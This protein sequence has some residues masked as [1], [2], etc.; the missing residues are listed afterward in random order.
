[1][2][3]NCIETIR[4][5]NYKGNMVDLS[6]FSTSDICFESIYMSL[7]RLPRFGGN[8]RVPYTVLKHTILGC[9]LCDSL[10]LPQTV[11]KAYFIHDMSEGVIGVDIPTP[12]KKACFSIQAIESRIQEVLFKS[13]NAEYC[14]EVKKLDYTMLWYECENLMPNSPAVLGWE[15]PPYSMPSKIVADIN[16]AT[17]QEFREEWNLL[18]LCLSQ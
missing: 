2:R 6:A 16:D 15:P 4:I 7:S 5:Q 14:D 18:L 11:R 9:R 13:F 17:K 3:N 8:T 1:M 10:G 12:V